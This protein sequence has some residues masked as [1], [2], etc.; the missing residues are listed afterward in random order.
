MPSSSAPGTRSRRTLAPVASSA[1]PKATSSLLE[2]FATR[3][4]VSSFITLVRVANSTP[5]EAHQSA[6]CR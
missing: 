1:L 3:A 2:S 5:L 4:P 6:G